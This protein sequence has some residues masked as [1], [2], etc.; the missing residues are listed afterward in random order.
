[1]ELY[2]Q[3]RKPL[4]SLV[5]T[6]AFFVIYA[7]INYVKH[8]AKKDTDLLARMVKLLTSIWE[9]TT[10]SAWCHPHLAPLEMCEW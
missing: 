5:A 1:M 2:S 8:L 3:Y 4:H 7:D 6:S 9:I 10:T